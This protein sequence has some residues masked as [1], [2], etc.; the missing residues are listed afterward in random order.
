MDFVL[1]DLPFGESEMLKSPSTIESMPLIIAQ[2]WEPPC[3]V[4]TYVFALVMFPFVLL[5]FFL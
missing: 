3:L 4:Q 2:N 1:D 5:S